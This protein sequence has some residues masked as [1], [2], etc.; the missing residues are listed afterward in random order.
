LHK[1]GDLNFCARFFLIISFL[2]LIL[3]SA[4]ADMTIWF[5]DGTSRQVRKIVF[6]GESAE[7]YLIDG[8]VMSVRTEQL[9][10]KSSGIP[11]PVGS[12][13][14]TKLTIPGTRTATPAKL[15]PAQGGLK[16]QQLK[17]EW[18]KSESV[19][20]AEKNIG[21]IRQGQKVKIISQPG[22]GI[23]NPY[24]E[25]SES[26]DDAYVIIYTNLDG[27]FAKRVFD[28]A[29]FASAFKIVSSQRAPA[30]EPSSTSAD[31]V[32]PPPEIEDGQNPGPL[33]LPQDSSVKKNSSL[34][35]P[36]PEAVSPVLRSH[37][38]RLIRRGER[39]F[40][41]VLA[42]LLL[43]GM[44]VAITAILMKR[45]RPAVFVDSSRFRKYEE[46]LRDFELEVYL[47][48][49]KTPEQLTEICVKKFYQDSPEALPVAM[50][51]LKTTDRNVIIPLIAKHTPK[52]TS[53]ADSI[54]LE[55]KHRIDSIRQLVR[56]AQ[57]RKAPPPPS[58]KPAVVTKPGDKTAPTLK[59]EPGAPPPNP[60]AKPV[61]IPETK[62]PTFLSP[63]D[64]VS[65]MRIAGSPSDL[66]AYFVNV[67]SQLSL[68]T[69]AE[70]SE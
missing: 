58:P 44:I 12:Y 34:D 15:A 56:E 30:V 67:L 20:V 70:P 32:P 3:S 7:L 52:G 27:T 40:P 42:G 57:A 17:E 33:T 37:G 39:R 26:T 22:S 38:P 51:M 19:A 61:Q 60:E 8:Q 4:Y 10:L 63:D 64:E 68:L 46:E 53:Q 43:I 23:P 62:T 35:Q 49:G 69:R 2:A 29:T 36:K 45:K 11:A 28:A 31:D 48:H 1:R 50:K 9:D 21:T 55:M 18:E 24:M 25:G 5:Q 54:Y 47:K 59:R 16:Q 65:D 41:V 66:P 13:G 14:E 6:K